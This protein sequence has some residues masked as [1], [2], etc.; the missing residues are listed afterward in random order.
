AGQ[1]A[2]PPKA[3][4]AVSRQRH[5]WLE[6]TRPI[7]IPLAANAAPTRRAWAR[8]SSER[9]RWVEHSSRR[10]PGGSPSERSV[11]AWRM[12]MTWPPARRSAH[13][14]SS[15]AARRGAARAGADDDHA[16]RRADEYGGRQ[17]RLAR[18]L[19]DDPRTYALAQRVPERL[20]ERTGA[21]RPL[22]VG[23]GVLGIGQGTPVRELAAVDDARG[24]VIDAELPLRLVGDD[25]DR[26]AADGARDLERHAPEPA[27]RS[28]DQNHIPALDDVGRPA[29]EHPVRRGSAEEEAARRL[30]GQPLRLRN[31][32]MGLAAG[33]LAV[34]AIVG[35]IAPDARRFGEHRVPAR[36]H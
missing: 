11:A 24:A 36:A 8:P 27:G 21:F 6:S 15:A 5:H 33:K 22:A 26:P 28:P 25:R 32:L 1:G 2:A 4:R 17:R 23:T 13:S 14:A 30:P 34:A 31:T 9:L 3:R 12:T 16:A 18:V 35:L 29:H 10:K 20:A 7:G 19:E